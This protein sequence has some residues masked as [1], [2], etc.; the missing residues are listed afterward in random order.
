MKTITYVQYCCYV[1]ATIHDYLQDHPF[2]KVEMV[3]P[4][5]LVMLDGNEGP[6]I[7]VIDMQFFYQQYLD[8]SD[9][10]ETVRKIAQKRVQ[11]GKQAKVKENE[12]LKMLAERYPEQFRGEVSQYERSCE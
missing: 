7:P 5:G 2:K 9:L 11:M 4:H 8:G 6:F 1:I 3:P 12:W 10:D